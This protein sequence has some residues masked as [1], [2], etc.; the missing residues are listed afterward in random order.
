[1]SDRAL[2]RSSG[3]DIGHVLDKVE[4]ATGYAPRRVGEGRWVARCPAHEDSHPSLSIKL[5]PDESRLLLYDFGGC[6]T[7]D[8]L[9]AAGLSWGA[10]FA[11][12]TASSEHLSRSER[13]RS[14]G[15]ARPFRGSSSSAGVG[16]METAQARRSARA[17]EEENVSEFRASVFF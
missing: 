12:Q 14:S 7:E 4:A 3:L 6:A 5:A 17:E 16:G 15:A 1:M 10:L 13:N 11:D 9:A 2:S 8:V